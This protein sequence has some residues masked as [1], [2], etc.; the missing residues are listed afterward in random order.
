ML[1]IKTGQTIIVLWVSVYLQSPTSNEKKEKKRMRVANWPSSNKTNLVIDWYARVKP[2]TYYDFTHELNETCVT[3]SLNS[4]SWHCQYENWAGTIPI[5]Q[6]NNLLQCT[7]VFEICFKYRTMYKMFFIHL[8]K[9]CSKH[10][11][12]W[13][14]IC[15]SDE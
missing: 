7:V 13:S 6:V 12:Y 10:V 2:Y 14:N 1:L 5:N 9:D 8:S 3:L 11:V 15:S 4:I